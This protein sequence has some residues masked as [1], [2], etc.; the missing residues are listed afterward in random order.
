[1]PARTPAAV[2]LGDA[3]PL[4]AR[5]APEAPEAPVSPAW[6]VLDEQDARR[7]GQPNQR[8]ASAGAP[9]TRATPPPALERKWATS[10]VANASLTP[11]KAARDPYIV[12]VNRQGEQLV[13]SVMTCEELNDRAALFTTEYM[14]RHHAD[15]LAECA[16]LHVESVP[17]LQNLPPRVN[18]R[19]RT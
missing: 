14:L 6:T 13:W 18:A 2:P 9:R 16:A 11:R 15:L 8:R 1:M 7:F 10:G 5:P 17:G 12:G 3:A 4:A 19:D